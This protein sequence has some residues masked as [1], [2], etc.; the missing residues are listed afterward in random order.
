M[1][2]ERRASPRDTLSLPI[3]LADGGSA[4]TRNLS[5]DGLFFTVPAGS[6]LDDWLHVE[7]AVPSAGLQFSAAGEV[8]RIEHGQHEDG[9]ALRL[10][11][12]RL[13]ALP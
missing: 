9:V 8:V 10:H 11:Q 7:F 6:R 1:H 13:T 2:P 12:P 4:M 3:A 5:A